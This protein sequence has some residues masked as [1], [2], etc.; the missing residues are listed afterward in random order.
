MKKHCALILSLLGF[1]IVQAQDLK[2]EFRNDLRNDY[3]I[4]GAWYIVIT[5]NTGYHQ[6]I[7]WRCTDIYGRY[8]D[9][10]IY[11]YSGNETWVGPNVGW[12]WENGETFTYSVS[13]GYPR[14]VS[15]NSN[16]VNWVAV[17]VR[18]TRKHKSC[19]CTTYKGL[20][21]KGIN[22]YSGNCTNIVNG[23]ECGHSPKDHGLTEY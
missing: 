19:S 2:V 6:Q 7:D 10:N 4:Y 11:L 14:Q 5:N 9:G 3:C 22:Q 18:G 20:K 21:R 8:K 1:L 15:F 13:R 16:S 23:H 17:E 12:I